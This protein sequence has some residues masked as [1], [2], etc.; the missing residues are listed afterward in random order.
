MNLLSLLTKEKRVAGIEISD[1]VVRIAF[2]RPNGKR[3]IKDA[4]EEVALD[5]E[6]ILIEEPIGAN[7]IAD[8]VVVDGDLL[9]KTLS[10]IWEKANLGTNYAIVAIPDDKIYSK[11]FSFPKSVTNERLTEAMRLAITFQL[12][13]KTADTYLDWERTAGTSTT[14][15]ILLSTIPRTVAHGYVEALEKAGIKILALESHLAAIARAVNLTPGET[16]LFSKK[17]PDGATVFALKDGILRFSRTL[18]LRF[19]PEDKIPEETKRIKDA[20]SVEVKGAKEPSVEIHEQELLDANVGGAYAERPELTNP[21]S[22]WLVALGAA[23]RGKI[24]E[25]QDNLVSLLPIGTEEAY[26]YQRA[27]AFIVLMR[28]LVIG[29]SIFFVVAYLSAYLFMLSLSQNTTNQITTLSASAMPP[30]FAE[31]EQRVT[32]INSITETGALFLAQMPAWDTVL[33]ELVAR[34][35]DGVTISMFSAPVFTERMSLTGVAA[36]RTVLNNYKKI[37]QESPLLSEVEI[38]LSNLEQKGSIPFTA[39][40]RLKDPNALYFSTKTQ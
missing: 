17:T 4:K 12:P 28:N 9:A 1:S 37:L 25:G 30:E 40:F 26:S 14:N 39:S 19:V 27:T 33:T 20:L 34:T 24:P 36:S 18:P 3:Q 35:P 16:T 13:M 10:S 22:K 32:D 6:L 29:V 15:E 21:K 23:I 38:P 8:G 11:V 31:M 2:F 5:D 7:I